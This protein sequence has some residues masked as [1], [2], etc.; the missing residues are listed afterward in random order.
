M[1]SIELTGEA[2]DAIG[3]R[4]VFDLKVNYGKGKTVS[5][6]GT[7]SVSVAIPYTL[8]AKEKAG[9][10]QA[11]Y[12]DK[13]GRIQWLE[14]SV[15]DSIEKVLRFSTDHFSNYGIGYKKTDTTFKDISGHWAKE[16]IEFVVSRGLISGT[17]ATKF[18]PNSGLT[19]G[20]FATTLGRLANANV[21]PYKKSSFNDV[22]KDAYNMG[23]IEWASKKNIIN[24]VDNNKFAPD[25]VITREQ[26]AVIMSNYIKSIDYDLPKVYMKNTFADNAKISANAKNAVKEL[27]MAGIISSKNGNIFD[28]QGTA[29]RAEASAMLR[30]FMKLTI[31]SNA[32][33]G[34][35]RNDSGNWMYYENGQPVTGKKEIEGVTYTFDQYGVTAAVPK[36]L[37]STSNTS[38]KGDKKTN[39]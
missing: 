14:N 7:G 36:N 2:D 21:S 26:L 8:G 31:S 13:K 30:R 6:F 34:W 19:R 11:V 20:V 39:Q 28:P 3:S 33:Q 12:V 25:Q 32:V 17:S 4:P 29:T 37:Q 10:V 38:Q 27:Q 9:N 22:K 24:A 23:Y 1:D 15:Y 5:N 18:A 16:D 35:M